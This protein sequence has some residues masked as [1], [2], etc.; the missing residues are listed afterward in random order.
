MSRLEDAI[1]RSRAALLAHEEQ[2]SSELLQ[3]YGTAAYTRISEHLDTLTQQIVWRQRRGQDVSQ[4]ALFRHTRLQALLLQI[5]DEMEHFAGYADGRIADAQRIAILDANLHSRELIT[6]S[7]GVPHVDVPD[8]FKHLNTPAVEHM[9]GR[10]S[11]GSPLR[12]LLGE[13]APNAVNKARET[14]AAGLAEGKNPRL[15][16]QDLRSDLNIPIARA[17]TI[18]RTET[19]STYRAVALENYRA[20]SDVCRGWIWNCARSY[21][22]CAMCLAMDGQ[23][24]GLDVPFSSHCNCRCSP[25]PVTV[26]WEDLGAVD[27]EDTSAGASDR[28]T[29]AE[30]F[31]RQPERVQMDVLGPSKLREYQAGRLTLQDLVGYRVDKDWGPQRWERSLTQVRKGV[32]G[33]RLR[34]QE[35]GSS[36]REGNR[37]HVSNIRS[38][39]SWSYR[40]TP[41]PAQ[42]RVNLSHIESGLR[43]LKTE[44]GYAL[45]PAGAVA[46]KVVAIPGKPF[47]LQIMPEDYVRMSGCTF[48]HNHPRGRSFS[49]SDVQ[50]ASCTGLAEIRAITPRGE[51]FSLSPGPDG[52]DAKMWQTVIRPAIAES[53]NAV[54]MEIR[55]LIADG[56]LTEAAAE[57]EQPSMVMERMAKKCGL[58]Y[59]RERQ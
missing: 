9:V 26:S 50:L 47:E 31:D 55:T 17:Q 6:A 33:E 18:A 25:V 10:L 23:E 21:R 1:A 14:L 20:N 46:L 5:H 32:Y 54:R 29:G 58:I 49:D 59:R 16:A 15:V 28:E 34:A 36:K 8:A 13:I 51:V 12:S 24:F 3:A 22:T 42:L 2:V 35:P 57:I 43:E 44:E 45:D 53:L 39:M 7:S 27:I 37:S 38:E 4:G 52:W 30:W 48:T 11:D 40:I 41:D 19:L 56:R